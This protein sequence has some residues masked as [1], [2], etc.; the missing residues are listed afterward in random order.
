MPLFIVSGIIDRDGRVGQ[1]C[2]G[3]IEI[4][5]SKQGREGVELVGVD[6]RYI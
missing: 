6:K 5:F 4:D 2:S 3:E 1:R